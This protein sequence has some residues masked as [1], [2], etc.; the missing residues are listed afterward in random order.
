MLQLTP[1]PIETP[2]LILRPFLETDAPS[3]YRNWASDSRVTRFLTWPTHASPEVTLAVIRHW[4]STSACEWC[5]VPREFNEPMGSLGVV[6]VDES[7]GTVELGYCLS[8]T[9]W[10]KGYAAEALSAVISA[11]FSNPAVRRI[12]A[13]HDLE[14]PNSGRVMQKA[15]MSFLE[16]RAAAVINHL[17]LRDVAVYSISNPNP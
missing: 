6:S 11:L 8:Q 15:G 10:G 1:S 7:T 5:I 4:I 13:K 17:G 12:T 16:N 9:C 3:M 14:N 2:R